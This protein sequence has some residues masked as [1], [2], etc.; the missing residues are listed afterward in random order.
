MA[1]RRRAGLARSRK[2]NARPDSL[3]FRDRMYVPTLVEVPTTRP[4]ARYLKYQVPILDQ[5]QEGACTGFGLAT[6][7]HYLLRTRRSAASRVAVSPR[8]FYEMARRYDE[9]PGEDYEGSSARGAMKGWQKHGVCGE[10]HWPYDDAKREDRLFAKRWSDALG[11]PLGAYFR[12]NHKDVVAMHSAI[13]EA[14]VLFATASV[15]GGWDSVGRDGIIEQESEIL[16]GHAFAIVAYDH[17]GLWIQNSWGRDWGNR[18]FGRISYD[19]WLANGTDVWVA[20]LGAPIKLADPASTAVGVSS[21]ARGSRGYAYCHLRPHVISIGNDGALRTDGTFGTDVD[22][23]ATI[24]TKDIPNATKRWRRKRI[25]LYA[26]GGLVPEDSA[27][28]RVAEYR[29]ALFEH[30]VYPV[31]FVWKTDF[32]S[33]IKNIVEDALSRRKPEGFLDATKDFMLERLD[34]ALEPLARQLSGKSEW[35]EMKENAELA[36]TS[37]MGGARIALRHLDALLAQDEYEVHVVAHSA[38][39]IFMAR[40]VQLLTSDVV[41]RGPLEGQQGYGRTVETCTLWAPACTSELFHEAYLPAIHDGGIKRFGLFTLTDHAEQDDS[42]ANVYHKSL[43]YLVSNAFERQPRI[44][45]FRD[46]VPI[47]GMEKWVAKDA[48]LTALFGTPKAEW[49][50]SPNDAPQGSPMAARAR[51][52]GDFDDD[53][54]TVQATLQRIVGVAVGAGGP[55]FARTGAGQR[56][57]REG[58]MTAG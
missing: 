37:A 8:M 24:F 10:D 27:I 58:L 23:V 9:W 36:T 29:A 30:E 45:L 40:L 5:G 20:R 18:G 44:P 46:G 42:C 50:R 55:E 54:A 22:A 19:D 4:L 13:T 57:V 52:H 11:R 31:T 1:T 2:L 3:D 38:G 32:W 39:A 12:V 47:V 21:A 51:A 56:V 7:A 49:V 43:L 16:G 28:Q 14:G 34:D 33:T 35:D 6:V 15:H 48:E 25:L 26:H 41:A 53:R 17:E